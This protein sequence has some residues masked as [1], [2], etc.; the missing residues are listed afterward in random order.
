MDDVDEDVASLKDKFA[1]KTGKAQI[2]ETSLEKTRISLE[3]SSTL[4][5]K[6]DEERER[7]KGQMD[8]FGENIK[9]LP[10]KCIF[11][12][13]FL[14]FRW[15]ARFFDVWNHAIESINFRWEYLKVVSFMVKESEIL[16]WKSKGLSDYKEAF[17]NACLSL[18]LAIH[19]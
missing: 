2:L 17:E 9:L 8:H 18:T 15:N 16:G 11:A 4:L 14:I 13:N 7:W 10:Q 6:L 3:K 19:A 5:S 1:K 12:S